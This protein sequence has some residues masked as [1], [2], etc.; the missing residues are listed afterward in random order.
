M[1]KALGLARV[2]CELPEPRRNAFV[3]FE[4]LSHTIIITLKLCHGYPSGGLFGNAFQVTQ[5]CAT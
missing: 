3:V 1:W 2:E 4:R 5:E